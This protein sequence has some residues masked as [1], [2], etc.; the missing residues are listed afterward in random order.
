M[1]TSSVLSDRS[2]S[3]T[4]SFAGLFWL[5]SGAIVVIDWFSPADLVGVAFWFGGIACCLTVR[6]YLVQMHCREVSAFK[7][8]VEYGR[9]HADK[10]QPR[11]RPVR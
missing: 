7:A 4:Y 1:Q 8:G 9:N 5:I 10:E 2:F 11:M 6:G 3:I